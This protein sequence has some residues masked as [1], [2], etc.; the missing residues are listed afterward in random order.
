MSKNSQPFSSIVSINPYQGV[1]FSSVGNHIKRETQ[2]EYEKKQFSIAFLNT[3]SFITALIGISKNIPD[4]DIYDAL[5]NKVYE[6]LALDMAVEYKINFIEAV[7]VIDEND[8]FFHVFIVDPLTIEEEFSDV[9]KQIKYLDQIIPLPLLYKSL[10]QREII[11]DNGLHCYIYFQENDASLTIYDDQNF[12][13]TKSLKYSFKMMHERFIELLGEQIGYEQFITFLGNDG[14][15]VANTEYQK[16]LIKLFGELFLHINDVLTYAKRAFEIKQIDFVYIG[17][18]VGLING[19]DEYAQTYLGLATMPFDFN[20]GFTSEEFEVDQIHSLMHLYN[21]VDEDE[22]YECNF[23]QYHRPPPFIKRQS[24]KII[25]LTI[26]SLVGAMLYPV[27]YW[28]LEYIEDMHHAVLSDEYRQ[29]HN[30]RIT[31]EATINLKLADL[32]KYQTLLD[33]EIAEYKKS[34]VTLMKIHDVKINYPMKAKN[35]ASFTKD[36]NKYDAGIKEISYSESNETGK[37]FIFTLVS[38]KDKQLT[39]LLKYL[40]AKRSKTYSFRMNQIIYKDEDKQYSTQ[41]KAVIK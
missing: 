9:I 14:L 28:T 18:Q 30:I 23:T 12:I 33:G 6:E 32:K 4:E 8:Q 24:G 15:N 20:Y 25:M 36:F 19:L 11:E 7:D 26:A 13:Y 27:T 34:K 38:K 29:L 2:P 17:S 39:D 16:Y 1:Y 21:Q 22:R 5:E 10:Y 31:R 3:K 40:T 41:L 37:E 35:M